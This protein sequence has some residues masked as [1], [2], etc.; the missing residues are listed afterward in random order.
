MTHCARFCP[1]PAGPRNARARSRSPAAPTRFCRRR[2]ASAQP[3]PPRSRRQASPPPISGNCATGR[4][5]EVAVDLRQAVASLRSGHYLQVSGTKVRGERNPVMG[6]YPAKNWPL[7]LHPRQ[8][9]E[10]SR[11][12]VARTRL[13][14]KPRGGAA[15]SG[16]LGRARAR[17]SDYRRRR[18][19]RH[20]AQHGRVGAASAGC[21]DR[22][23]AVAGD[24]QDRRQPAGETARGRP[25]LVGHSRPR[26]DPR[27]GRSDLRPHPGRARRRRV[28]DHRPAYRRTR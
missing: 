11:R 24:P 9:P 16:E 13:R 10:P 1:P 4:R 12:R 20:G 3:A 26:P 23:V 19:R 21:G 15:R 17:G 7:E 14:G 28:E 18:C 27:A 22:L 8:F 6:M 5:Q 25:P 2:S